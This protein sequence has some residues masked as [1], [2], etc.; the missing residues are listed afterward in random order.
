M[1]RAPGHSVCLKSMLMT[2]T[3]QGLTLE[4]IIAAEK[5][6]RLDVNC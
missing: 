1:S 4:A 6:N 5:H 3:M 2:V